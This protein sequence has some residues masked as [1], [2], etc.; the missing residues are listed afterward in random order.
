[1]DKHQIME[2]MRDEDFVNEILDMQTTEEVKEAFEKKGIEI[3]LEEFDIISQII[4]KMVDRNTT[5]LSDDDLEEISGGTFVSGGRSAF[6]NVSQSFS[7]A[8]SNTTDFGAAAAYGSMAAAL[9]A[10][11]IAGKIIYDKTKNG[12]KWLKNGG[13]SQ[14]QKTT[15]TT[16]KTVT[17]ITTT[18]KKIH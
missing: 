13:N 10:T 11:G 12:I 3:S 6:N 14:D 17:T 18:T 5:E 16:T 15:T 1:M 8:T 7:G 9:I 4:N 2:V